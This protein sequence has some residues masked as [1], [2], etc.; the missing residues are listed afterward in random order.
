MFLTNKDAPNYCLVAIDLDKPSEEKWT[1]LIKVMISNLVNSECLWC[2]VDIEFII[3]I[4]QYVGT[5]N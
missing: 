5:S 2:H 4:L 3:L 1:T